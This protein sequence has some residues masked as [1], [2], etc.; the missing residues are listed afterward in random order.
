VDPEA[1]GFEE[2]PHE[3]DAHV[4]RRLPAAAVTVAA[5]NLTTT[6]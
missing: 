5:A 4:T 1:P 3:R 6:A 2:P